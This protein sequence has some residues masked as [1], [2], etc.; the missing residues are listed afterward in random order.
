MGEAGD[1]PTASDRTLRAFWHDD[2]LD[3]RPPAGEFK[4]PWTGRLDHR[5]PHPDRPERVRNIRSILDAEL[6]DVV[7]WRDAPEATTDQLERVHDPDYLDDLWAACDRAAEE[8][9]YLLLPN[10]GVS[11]GTGRAARRA[12]GGAVAAAEAALETGPETL[13]YACVRPSGH[14]AGPA[15]TD[16]FCYLNNVAVAAEAVR[17]SG[18]A[19]RVAILDWDVHHGNGTQ[20]CF[21][22]RDDV[23]VISL[24]NDHGSW[25]PETHPET[26]AVEERGVGDGEGYTVN[27]P[28]PA[29]VGD[30]GYAD[31]FDRLVTPVV[32]EYDPDLILCSAGG[33]AGAIEPLG[34]NLVTV[35]GFER[36]G[37]AV[38]RLTQDAACGSLAFV[39]EGGYQVTHLPYAMHA[40]LAGALGT[41][42]DIDDPMAW[43]PEQYD[44]LR[45]H[46]D[47]VVAA[48]AEFWPVG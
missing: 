21:Y 43:L 26:G 28:L 16:G 32:R 13:S 17:A 18:A 22:D 25:D 47:D 33:D 27:A 20:T 19:D 44:L 40:T 10:T 37:R 2:C 8:G 45:P 7:D 31:L 36:I 1:Q 3:H 24:H 48:H 14:H 12:A 39:Q 6:G 30:E 23:L 9:P 35:D 15:T 29:G 5:D 34:R 41:D 46:V 38:D 4:A 11:E 42:P